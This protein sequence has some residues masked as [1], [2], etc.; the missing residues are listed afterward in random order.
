MDGDSPVSV[1]S[2]YGLGIRGSDPVRNRDFS[3]Y[4][5]V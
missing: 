1:V 2:G 4:T 5:C 3:L